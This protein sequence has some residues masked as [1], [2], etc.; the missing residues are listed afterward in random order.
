MSIVQGRRKI[1][2]IIRGTF[3]RV[4]QVIAYNTFPYKFTNFLHRLRGV[5][6]GEKSHVSRNVYIDDMTPELVK[7]GK[8]VAICAGVMILSHQR[9]LKYYNKKNMY[10]MECPFIEK[11]VVIHDGA[12]IGI[13]AIILPGVTIG[14]GAIIGAGSVVSN[15]IP[16]YCVAVG[17]PAKV[18][19][20]LDLE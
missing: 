5:E 3:N 7:I 2:T 18:I 19:K 17:T 6:I 11:E 12:H 8:G 16:E 15:D 20:K 14:K 10:V 13:G 9:N 4:L 1:R